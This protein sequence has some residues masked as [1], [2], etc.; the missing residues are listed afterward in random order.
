MILIQL[1]FQKMLLYVL[2]GAISND[3]KYV[4]IGGIDL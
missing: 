2:V 4:V 1:L 3:L